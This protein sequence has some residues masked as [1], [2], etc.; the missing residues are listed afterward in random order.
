[1][2]QAQAV[3]VKQPLQVGPS[4]DVEPLLRGARAL[5]A[6]RV[7]KTLALGRA[8]RYEGRGENTGRLFEL[9]PDGR[10]FEVRES[11]GAIER[12]REVASQ[13]RPLIRRIS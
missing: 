9:A 12:I 7:K 3:P 6:E 1:M 13:G 10:T 8:I 5:A 11:N 2:K 4:S